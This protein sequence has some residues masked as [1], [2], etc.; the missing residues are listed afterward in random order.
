MELTLTPIKQVFYNP[1]NDYRVLSCV[2]N[3]WNAQ[4]E[5]NKY[6][7]FTLSGCNLMGLVLNQ[8]VSLTWL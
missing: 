4:V 2:P 3:D 1:E 7:N 6:G 8:S 5:L